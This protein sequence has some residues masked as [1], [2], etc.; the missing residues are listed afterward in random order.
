MNAAALRARAVDLSFAAGW[1]AIKAIPEPVA[2]RVFQAVAQAAPVRNG[3]GARRLRANLR[4]VVPHASPADLDELVAAAL[5]SYARYWL[6]T[7]R[8]P[9]MDRREV[10]ARVDGTTVGAE[11]ID[12]AAAEGKGFILALPH[13]GNWEVAA[14]WLIDR[15]Y[16]FA[17]VAERLK[18]ESLFNRFV[19]Y[20]ESLGIEVLPLTGGQAAP[21]DVLAERLRS[22]GAVCLVADRDLSRSGVE[23]SFF[24]E[25]AKM[26]GGPALLAAK[27]GA[28]LLP[29]CLW[30]QDDGWGQWIGE[31]IELRGQRLADKVRSGTQTLA[32]AFAERIA[33]HPADW[34]MLQRLWLA[35]LEVRD[36]GLN[37]HRP[38]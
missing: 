36:A 34:H 12:A 32:N 3:K 27:T 24:G 26:P 11:R 14:L 7:F 15:G 10:V 1:G 21:V 9:R 25:T 18:P 30:F 19:E 2:S 38:G 13:S 17:T 29:V 23:V 37:G 28:A 16:P 8:L 20:R 33:L 5:R 35:D 22:G 4:R 31:P 6:E